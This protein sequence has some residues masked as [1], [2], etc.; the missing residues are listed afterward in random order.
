MKPSGR[1][2]IWRIGV[3]AFAQQLHQLF[4]L[5]YQIVLIGSEHGCRQLILPV[6]GNRQFLLLLA[7]NFRLSPTFA[8][9]CSNRIR[10]RFLILP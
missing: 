9:P 1:E 5:I 4:T 2:G 7:S 10:M 6:D 8:N 3:E